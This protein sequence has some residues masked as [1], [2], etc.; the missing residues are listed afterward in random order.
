[1]MKAIAMITVLRALALRNKHLDLLP[2]QLI[3]GIAKHRLRLG[4]DLNDDA[5]LIHFGDGIGNCF[6]HAAR[7]QGLGCDLWIGLHHASRIKEGCEPRVAGTTCAYYT[8]KK[9]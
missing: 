4:V 1:M 2:D 5:S 7:Q 8:S 6:E 3:P 9:I